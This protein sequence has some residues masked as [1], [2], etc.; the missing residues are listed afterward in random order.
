[1]STNNADTIRA[2]YTAFGRG[3]VPAILEHVADDVEWEFA[4]GAGD[5][6][7]WLVPRR[8][9][10]GAAAFFQ[11]AAEHLEFSR[12]QI[13]HLLA[14]GPLVIALASLEARVKSTGKVI[15]ENQEPH[16]WHFDE[17]GRV[18]RFR[19]AA[20]TLQQYRALQR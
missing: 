3:D 7:P 15:R 19:H 10:A 14:D 18:I 9:R 1:M 13:D 12:F 2:I 16:V 4:Y 20:D 8:G 17:R 6:I 5:G 11:S